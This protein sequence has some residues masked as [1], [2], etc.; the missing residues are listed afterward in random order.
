MKKPIESIIGTFLIFGLAVATTSCG[1]KESNP[2]GAYQ[3]LD[4]KP[5]TPVK[6]DTGAYL[7]SDVFNI[8]ADPEMSF[9]TGQESEYKFTVSIYASAPVEYHLEA[10]D[11]PASATLTRSTEAKEPQTWILKW[12]PSDRDLVPNLPVT[13]IHIELSIKVLSVADQALARALQ[14]TSYSRKYSLFVRSGQSSQMKIVGFP[15]SVKEGE[16]RP[17]QVVIETEQTAVPPR[18]DSYFVGS[19][20][21]SYE[22][23]EFLSESATAFVQLEKSDPK[24]INNEDNGNPSGWYFSYLFTT[25]NQSI[26]KARKNVST[27]RT[28]AKFVPVQLSFKSF[29]RGSC[30]STP[31]QLMTTL[32]YYKDEDLKKKDSSSPKIHKNPRPGGKKK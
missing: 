22:G 5:E 25:K 1:R 18:I 8:K 29:D 2:V 3:N 24:Y 19:Q 23:N 6:S 20:Q 14:N 11:L 13:P 16:S 28:E 26:P 4:L 27:Q 17:F 32:I 21:L 30:A 10:R 15:E 31:E 9:V 12:K 7:A